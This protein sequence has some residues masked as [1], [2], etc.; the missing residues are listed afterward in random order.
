MR[1]VVQILLFS[2]VLALTVVLVG[3]ESDENKIEIKNI[4]IP[5]IKI[6]SSGG[7]DM[8]HPIF[9]IAQLL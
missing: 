2:K 9:T 8:W 1:S 4:L 6:A 5:V 7:Q 3:F